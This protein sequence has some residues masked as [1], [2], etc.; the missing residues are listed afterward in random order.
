MV[1]VPTG[2][3]VFMQG[4]GEIPQQLR[5]FAA[6][7]ENQHSPTSTHVRETDTHLLHLLEEIQ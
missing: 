4:A 6:L 7:S 1:N 5:V 3:S 2:T